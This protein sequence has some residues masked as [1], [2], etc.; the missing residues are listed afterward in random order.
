VKTLEFKLTLSPSQQ[1]DIDRWLN[2]LKRIWNRGLALLEWRQHYSRLQEC[3]VVPEDRVAHWG[4]DLHPVVIRKHKVGDE[5]LSYCDRA[6]EF[7]VDRTLGREIEGNLELRPAVNLVKAH[8][9][10]PP[11]L[12]GA[13]KIAL[14][15]PFAK[16]RWPE[17]GDI[18]SVYLNDYIGLVLTSAWEKYQKG[19]RQKPRYKR[20]RD[21]VNTIAS[22]S[23][24][25]V[26]TLE[27]RKL[28]LPGLG[29]LTVKGLDERLTNPLQ[30]LAQ[31]MRAQPH[32][33]PQLANQLKEGKALEEAI[34][35]ATT[36][37][38]FHICRKASG[39]YLQITAVLPGRQRHSHSRQEVAGIAAG[40]ISFY[41]I[42]SGH[43]AAPVKAFLTMEDKIIQAQRRLSP[44]KGR[45][46]PPKVGSNNYTK[47]QQHIATLHEKVRRSRRAHQHWH[48]T[49]VVDVYKNLILQDLDVHSLLSRPEPTIAPEGDQYLPNGAELQSKVNKA[50]AN[51]AGGQFRAL[52]EAK[53]QSRGRTSDRVTP[54]Q[55]KELLGEI[56]ENRQTL[57]RAMLSLYPGATGELT[58]A[59]SSTEETMKQESQT[60][61]SGT[62]K[63][64]SPGGISDNL[65]DLQAQPPV[66]DVPQRGH[67]TS[68]NTAAKRTPR[69]PKR[70]K[71]LAKRECQLLSEMGDLDDE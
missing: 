50:F 65:Q 52:L 6:A 3:L 69:C 7:R 54:A 15:K 46:Y 68:V 34:I 4:F 19:E 48:S 47:R 40:A 70:R 16:K 8:W 13:S 63:T 37:G 2:I 26:C 41:T 23:F 32:A 56:P 58:P 9:Q 71:M 64:D 42:S 14:R 29:W 51:A 17:S 28:K 22:E 31:Q 45:K 49:G 57:A 60:A 62:A 53:A 38:A 59:E 55:L 12:T 43:A 5:W 61:R 21:K 10:T 66:P 11:L 30:E 67:P 24:R 35:H 36:P 1:F 44:R 33:Y 25:A 39:Y 20:R 27:G 18:P